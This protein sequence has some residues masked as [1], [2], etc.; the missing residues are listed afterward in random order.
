MNLKV[1]IRKDFGLPVRSEAE[2]VDGQMFNFV[3][4]WIIDNA[5]HYKGEIAMIPRDETYPIEA[6][7]WIASGDLVEI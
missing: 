1:Q 7:A 2:V 5:P 4:G 3:E 6:P